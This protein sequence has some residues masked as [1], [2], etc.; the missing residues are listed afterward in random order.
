[1]YNR[2]KSY[3]QPSMDTKKSSFC[4]HRISRRMFR[5]RHFFDSIFSYGEKWEQILFCVTL[6]LLLGRVAKRMNFREVLVRCVV[7]SSNP[8]DK[9]SASPE[10]AHLICKIGLDYIFKG[11]PPE[12]IT[13]MHTKK[14]FEVVLGIS[15]SFGVAEYSAFTFRTSWEVAT[16]LVI[17][18]RHALAGRLPVRSFPRVDTRA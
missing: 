18:S 3:F 13:F 8:L 1:M 6:C 16:Q 4:L 15:G 7:T 2:V 12:C 17:F 10:F 14:V 5:R 9:N 11:M